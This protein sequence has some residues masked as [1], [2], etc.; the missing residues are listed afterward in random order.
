MIDAPGQYTDVISLGCG[1]QH[2]TLC[3]PTTTSGSR[4]FGWEFSVF[5]SG[6]GM[7]IDGADIS[8]DVDVWNAMGPLGISI[9]FNEVN[10][11]RIASFYSNIQSFVLV[12]EPDASS[13]IISCFLVA[14][15]LPSRG[16][17]RTELRITRSG[18]PP[19]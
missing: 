10:A 18:Y 1:P 3:M 19:V 8:N 15:I 16:C 4:E 17:S 13:M 12:P 11:L 14:I 7:L 9:A 2:S 6:P 5:V